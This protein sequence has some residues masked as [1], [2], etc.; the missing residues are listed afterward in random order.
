MGGFVTRCNVVAGTS[1]CLA[2][3]GEVYSQGGLGVSVAALIGVGSPPWQCH[4]LVVASGHSVNLAVNS[5]RSD[6]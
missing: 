5:A 3:N 2:S 1:G 4:L 6:C